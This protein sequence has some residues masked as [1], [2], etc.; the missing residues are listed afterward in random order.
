MADGAISYSVDNDGRF[1]KAI[2]AAYEA[3]GDLSI[4]FGLIAQDFYK[5]EQAIWQLGGPGQYPDL[6]GLKPTAKKTEAAKRAKERRFGFVYPLLKAT[7]FLE[8]SMT[9]PSGAGSVCE[10]G[11]STLILG[12]T[13]PYAIYHQ[14]DAPRRKIPLRKFLFIGPEAVQFATSDQMGRLERWLGILNGVV[15][16]KLAV[17][18]DVS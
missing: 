3:V 14:S 16:A 5:S 1:Q 10:I 13:V 6:G 9:S 4:A 8:Q 12:T 11:P 18:G 2:E 15:G 7:G 17:M